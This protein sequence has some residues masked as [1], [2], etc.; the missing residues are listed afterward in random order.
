MNGMQACNKLHC[1]AFLEGKIN[2]RKHNI[3]ELKKHDIVM[4]N[5]LNST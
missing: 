3:H 4:Q 2:S 5:S 1:L